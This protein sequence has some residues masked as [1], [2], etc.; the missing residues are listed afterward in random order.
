MTKEWKIKT[1]PSKWHGV[2]ANNGV[3]GWGGWNKDDLFRGN[4]VPFSLCFH[5]EKSTLNRRFNSLFRFL[6]HRLDVKEACWCNISHGIV[7]FSSHKPLYIA[8][9]L[10]YG[11]IV[12]SLELIFN[13]STCVRHSWDLKASVCARVSYR[14]DFKSLCAH[15]VHIWT[16]VNIQY[17]A[18]RWPSMFTY[19]SL[20]CVCLIVVKLALHNTVCGNAN[21]PHLSC[22]RS[23]W[24]WYFNKVEFKVTSA[25]ATEH[26]NLVEGGVN[27]IWTKKKSEA[28]RILF[29]KW[30]I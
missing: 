12:N 28:H 3:R 24:G 2:R 1:Y 11:W 29:W 7:S 25:E 14:T 22:F 10:I 13:W 20:P 6:K 30:C 27:T 23:A 15:S 19:Q 17:V 16:L 18:Q 21:L 4:F 8:V 9:K 5:A 26:A